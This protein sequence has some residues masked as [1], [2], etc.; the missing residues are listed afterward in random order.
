MTKETNNVSNEDT[1]EA[2]RL[3]GDVIGDTLDRVGIAALVK[4]AIPGC[5][6]S[7]RR[8][9]LNNLHKRLT[10]GS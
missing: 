5:N 3:L 10:G 8:K 7:G 4:K 6:C 1:T 9:A 2:K